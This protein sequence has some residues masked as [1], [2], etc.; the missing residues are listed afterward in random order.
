MSSKRFCHNCGAEVEE[1]IKFCSQCGARLDQTETP[2]SQSFSTTGKNYTGTPRGGEK[3][4]IE[5]VTTGYNVAFEQ[6]MV[7]LPPIISGVLGAIV[8]YGLYNFGMGD[9]L[10]TIL[11]LA[12]SMFSFILNFA[13]IDMSRDAYYKKPLD[14]MDSISYVTSRFFI[15]LL[16]AIFGGLLS[17]TIILIPV[18]LFMFVIMVLDE[19][20]IMDAFQKAISVLRSDLVDVL[21]IIILSIVASLIISYVPIVSTLLNAV[22]NV[23]IGIAFIDIYATYKAR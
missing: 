12:I 13:S 1:G 23:I 10:S 18:V 16:A 7:F 14:L 21:L 22:I 11:G 6:P 20:G 8:S 2:P 5:H 17:I 9:T 15:F 4:A 3:R 19:T